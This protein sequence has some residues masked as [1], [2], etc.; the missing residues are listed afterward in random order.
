MSVNPATPELM[1]D[2]DRDANRRTAVYRMYDKAGALLYVGI[3]FDPLSRWR[4]HQLAPWF[5]SV[6]E[7]WVEWYP[8]RDEA[9][10]AEKEA[11]RMESPLHNVVDHPV[12]D[13]RMQ[14]RDA[15]R[16]KRQ[17][18]QAGV[19]APLEPGETPGYI[20]CTMRPDE[21][22]SDFIARAAAARGP[23]SDS[24]V[25]RLRAIFQSSKPEP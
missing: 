25:V 22:V 10:A 4:Q 24:E 18:V 21:S 7:R 23:L 17:K 2:G 16:V 3:A 15:R 1:A 8:T 12:N 9:A 6:V 19:R 20:S 14:A 11:I 5:G 13:P